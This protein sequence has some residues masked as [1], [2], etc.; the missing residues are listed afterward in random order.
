M[1]IFFPPPYPSRTRQEA[2]AAR[3]YHTSSRSRLGL[4]SEFKAWA[5]CIAAASEHNLL[6]L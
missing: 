6:M 2:T 5:A 4:N 3:Q 1:E